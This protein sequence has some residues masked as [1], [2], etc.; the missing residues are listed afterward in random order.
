MYDY[1][2]V[3]IYGQTHTVIP[4]SNTWGLMRTDDGFL[5]FHLKNT[6]GVYFVTPQYHQIAPT[7][8][9]NRFILLIKMHDISYN[10]NK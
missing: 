4:Y 5:F 6:Y 7:L 2:C 8:Y 10:V 1:I 9:S 3:H